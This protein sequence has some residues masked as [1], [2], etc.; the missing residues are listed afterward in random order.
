MILQIVTAS[1]LFLDGG[2]WFNQATGLPR[3]SATT[4]GRAG[5]QHLFRCM[6]PRLPR[7]AEPGFDGRNNGSNNGGSFV[8]GLETEQ[9]FYE[10]ISSSFSD[11]FGRRPW[12][13]GSRDAGPRLRHPAGVRGGGERLQLAAGKRKRLIGDVN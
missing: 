3:G 7:Q 11:I 12:Q 5:I 9:D 1:A 10:Q 6:W 13:D 8:N 2:G 4:L